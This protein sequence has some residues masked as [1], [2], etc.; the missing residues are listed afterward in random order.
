[1][2]LEKPGSLLG[3]TVLSGLGK[4]LPGHTILNMADPV[5]QSRS[6]E[7][8]VYKIWDLV[9]VSIDHVVMKDS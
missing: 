9:A 4:P 5:T 2:D 8:N 7:H 3:K 1:M 6:T